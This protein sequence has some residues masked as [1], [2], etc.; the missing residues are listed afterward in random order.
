LD[1]TK[2]KNK[3]IIFDT[4]GIEFLKKSILDN[5][6]QYKVIESSPKKNSLLQLI[7]PIV[8]LLIFWYYIKRNYPDSFNWKKKIYCSYLSALVKMSNAEVIITYKG[9]FSLFFGAIANNILEKKFIGIAWAQVHERILKRTTL[10]HNI[11]YFVFGDYDVSAY[12]STG[13]DTRNII[14]VGGLIGGYYKTEISNENTTLKYDF[15]I[16]SQVLDMWFEAGV[17]Q[18]S[19]RKIGR[20]IFDKL[21]DYFVRYL[22]DNGDKNYKIAVALRPQ[23]KSLTKNQYEKEYFSEYLSNFDYDIIENNPGDF[24]TYRTMDIS[25]ILINHYSTSCFE[26]LSWDKKILFCQFYDYPKFPLPDDL[27]WKVIE[28]NYNTFKEK[29]DKLVNM[30]QKD[31]VE[32]IASIKNKYNKYCINNPP[33]KIIKKYLI[34]N[35][36]S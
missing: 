16:V 25:K 10:S 35:S 26:A 22:N 14:P 8:I 5:R 9:A 33:H 4:G 34:N 7:N 2:G 32:S 24:S 36:E 17:G 28:P 30:S 15:C 29:L 23:D 12:E 13:H 20:R 3:I 6:F 11:K 1:R 21:M 19:D 31:Y 18:I 27:P